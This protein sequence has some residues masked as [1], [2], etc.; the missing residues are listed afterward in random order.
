MV[1]M[2]VFFQRTK[3]NDRT[4]TSFCVYFSLKRMTMVRREEETET[5][6]KVPQPL[7]LIKIADLTA[8]LDSEY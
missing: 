1:M 4:K 5:S 8:R 3:S 2:V 6:P 7:I